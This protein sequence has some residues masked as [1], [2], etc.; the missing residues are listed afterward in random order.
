M[1][2]QTN[3]IIKRLG[4]LSH[5]L[6]FFIFIMFSRESAAEYGRAIQFK[7]IKLR[8]TY[9]PIPPL[10]N[11]STS[12]SP[13]SVVYDLTKNAEIGQ[14]KLIK[15]AGLS[16]YFNL[17]LYATLNSNKSIT[18]TEEVNCHGQ[19][20]W[21][22]ISQYNLQKNTSNTR[23]N[24]EVCKG[25]GSSDFKK[26]Y[27]YKAANINGAELP[28]CPYS[29]P[30]GHVIQTQNTAYAYSITYFSSVAN[31]TNST[32]TQCT[33][34]G[35]ITTEWVTAQNSGS[36]VTQGSHTYPLSKFQ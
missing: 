14:K 22:T 17:K 34:Q 16:N 2:R 33:Y 6:L 15:S 7:D 24:I 29:L 28:G 32:S 3:T 26:T 1:N 13:S 5:F 4:K 9:L 10:E 30:S 18:V 31:L 35:E 20:N 23:T 12:V 8:A 11:P 25:V 36:S 19:N 27:S 21:A